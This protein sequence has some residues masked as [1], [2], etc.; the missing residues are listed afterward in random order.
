MDFLSLLRIA[1]Q[2]LRINWLRSSLT[3]LGMVFGTG[4][5]IATL[6]SNEGAKAFVT[7]ELKKLGTNILS[8]QTTQGPPLKVGDAALL[9]KY[10]KNFKSIAF[11]I[12]VPGI[13]LQNQSKVL[14]AAVLG[15]DASYFANF[16]LSPARGRSFTTREMERADLVIVLGSKLASDLFGNADPIDRYVHLRKGDATL[17][18]LVIGALKPKGISSGINF[19]VSAYI[20]RNLAEKL[21][22]DAPIASISAM[23]ADDEASDA[24]KLDLAALIGGRYPGALQV[25]DAREAIERTQS[26]WKNQ[27]LV[28]LL[29][30]SISLLTGGIGIMNVMLLSINQRKR[31]I[32]LRRAIGATRISI[33]IQFLLEAVIVCFCGGVLG[34]G[35]GWIFGRQVAAMLGQWQSETSWTGIAVALTF[36]TLTGVFFGLFP[37]IRASRLAPVDA[38]R[39]M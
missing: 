7:Q 19:D 13:S 26:I 27:N 5:V 10:S 37:A 36:A 11:T 15:V 31:E 6:S 21:G 20:S 18:I 1:T 25:S 34:I 3:V 24:A 17:S 12:A 32:G 28:G 33:T 9:G 22:G 38:L 39:G 16:R 4:S 8:I 2:N 35:A 23:L 30:A 29:L 14:E